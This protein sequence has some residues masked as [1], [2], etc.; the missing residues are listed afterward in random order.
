MVL[1]TVPQYK[2]PGFLLG[3]GQKIYKRSLENLTVPESKEV[4]KQNKNK[5]WGI[6]K[7][8]EHTSGQSW[9]NLS[10]KIIIT[11]FNYNPS[12]K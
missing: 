10:N 2:E 7:G 6:L 4:L 12:L 8:K 1:N 3:L 9:K 5:I 11:Q